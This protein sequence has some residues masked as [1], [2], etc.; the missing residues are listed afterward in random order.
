MPEMEALMEP[1]PDKFEDALK[2]LMIPSSELDL[3]FD[4]YAKVICAIL[5]IPVRGNIIESLH[6]LFSLYS[7]FEG[8][9][10]FQAL[11]PQS[12]G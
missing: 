6:H 3:S 12:N 2:S 10:H 9:Q 8:N 7:E 4:D 1:W 5:E 11:R